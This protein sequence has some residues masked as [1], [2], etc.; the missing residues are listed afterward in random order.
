MRSPFLG[1]LHL[2]WC[3]RCHVPVLGRKCRCD[4]V[5]RE[6][7][8]T[9]P[10]DIRPAFAS[11]IER[12]NHVY[13]SHFGV[14]LIQEGQ[15]VLLNKIPDQDRM[16]EIILGGAVVGALRYLPSKQQWEPI[17]RFDAFSLMNPTKRYVIIDEDAV[18]SVRNGASVLAPGMVSIHDQVRAGD[19]VFILGE[20]GSY[21]GVGR[22][23]VN[24]SVARTMAHGSIV[25]TRKNVPGICVRGNATWAEVVAANEDI[26]S[27]YEGD[28]IQ[29][30]RNV[31]ENHPNLIPTVSYSGGKDSLA[32]F[33]IVMKA[34]GSIPILFADSG[35][36]FPETYENI[37]VVQERYGIEVVT[38]GNDGTFWQTFQEKGPP[39]IDARWCCTACK[40]Y[41]LNETIRERWGECLSFIGQRRYESFRRMT[42]AKIWRNPKVPCQLASAPIQQWTA[43]HVWLY[44]FREGAPYNALYEK[45]FDRVGCY[46]CPSS[47][48]ATMRMIEEISPD[49]WSGW[50]GRLQEWGRDNGH[51]DAWVTS[52]GWRIRG[53]KG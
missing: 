49:L 21:A 25:R 37:R 20:K 32:T 2:S 1:K 15:I 34:L 28:A 36:E 12:I 10:G 9:P 16:E 39:A 18:P 47:D 48:L 50:V 40:L 41:P 6:V 5:T 11:D 13:T 7:T 43:L 52:G 8:I 30:V 29:F 17:P 19:E 42:S 23:K 35:F 44:L 27:S 24:A 33:L 38:A 45:G 26:I 51:S 3:D 46:I 31:V 14:P 4:N 53:G 22:A